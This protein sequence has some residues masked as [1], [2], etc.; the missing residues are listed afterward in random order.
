VSGGGLIRRIRLILVRM[1]VPV[2]LV[3]ELRRH[4]EDDGRARVGRSSVVSLEGKGRVVIV[5]GQ[6]LLALSHQ[7]LHKASPAARTAK[8]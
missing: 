5:V 1:G 8:G 6:E 2:C 3:G 7:R 4:R